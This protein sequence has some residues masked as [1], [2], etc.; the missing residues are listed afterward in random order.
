MSSKKNHP[1]LA[2]V[3]ILNWNGWEDTF[4]CLE[5]LQPLCAAGEVGD[6]WLIDNGSRTDRTAECRSLLSQLR[7]IRFDENFGWAGGYNRALRQFLE[8][9]CLAAFLLNNDATVHPGFLTKL[10]QAMAADDQL[11]AIGST[12][13]YPDKCWV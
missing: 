5:S 12:I 2:P 4:A 13:V 11:A 7:V 9:G 10:C 3:L 6:V 8:K 1:G